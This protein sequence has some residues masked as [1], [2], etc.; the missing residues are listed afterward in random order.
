MKRGV[1]TIDAFLAITMMFFIALWLESFSNIG[2]NSAQSFGINAGLKEETIKIGSFMNSFFATNPSPG[3]Y[4]ILN[5]TMA[6]FGDKINLSIDK[7]LNDV[8]V[9]VGA[10]YNDI[11]YNLSYPVMAQI[12][13]NKT[14]QKVS[15]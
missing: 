8:K 9:S 10:Y 14:T 2:Y 11:T 6:L 5:D 1:N 15:A 3:E 4:V 12:K 13:Y 7:A